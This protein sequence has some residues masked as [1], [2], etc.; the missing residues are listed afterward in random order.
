MGV[1]IFQIGF[2]KC[3]TSTLFRYFERNGVP[4]IHWDHGD[5]AR[6][7][8]T[9]MAAGEDPFDHYRDVVF[10]SDMSYVT[11]NTVFD[12]YKHFDYIHRFYPDALFILNTRD[13]EAWVQSRINHPNLDARY[14]EAFGLKGRE[15]VMDYW[16]GEWDEHHARV[17]DFFADKPGQLLVFDIDRDGPAELAAFVAPHYRL[18]ADP[19]L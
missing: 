2:N 8:E 12:V 3:A 5:L 1:K 6:R 14:E 9:R 17:R 13:K 16:R 10:F 15:A 4:A 7:F 18:D 19:R 11:T